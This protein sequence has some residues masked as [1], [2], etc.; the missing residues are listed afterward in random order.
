MNAKLL[1]LTGA[2]LC[3]LSAQAQ[4]RSRLRPSDVCRGMFL[5]HRSTL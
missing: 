5:V 1:I 3:V 4:P 2:A